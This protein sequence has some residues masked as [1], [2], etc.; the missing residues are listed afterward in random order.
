MSETPAESEFMPKESFDSFYERVLKP[1]LQELE[2]ERRNI[3]STLLYPTIGLGTLALGLMAVL[4]NMGIQTM[5]LSAVTGVGLFTWFKTKASREFRGEFKNKVIR[6]IVRYCNKDYRYSGYGSIKRSDFESSNIM[7]R[8][9]DCYTGDDLITGESEHSVFSFS[10]VHSQIYVKDSKG[11]KSLQTQFKGLFFMADFN[12]HLQFH[13]VIVPDLAERFLGNMGQQ[14]QKLNFTRG[15]L[16]Q[17]ENVDFEKLFV[18]YG[19]D[20][21]EARYILTPKLMEKLVNYAERHELSPSL[22]FKG[23]H[24]YVAIPVT[25]DFFEPS[26]FS[27][28]MDKARCEEYYEDMQL[29]LSLIEELDLDNRIWS[30]QPEVKEEKASGNQQG[31]MGRSFRRR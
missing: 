5:I 16:V 13:T 27:T 25:K 26:I 31:R 3:R 22:A 6:E 19:T 21:V 11:R 23:N 28:L 30:K 10:E 24:V 17:M 12:K 4:P 18:V 29:A 2:Q 1:A 9:P 8:R 7:T 20:Q 15:D 14:L